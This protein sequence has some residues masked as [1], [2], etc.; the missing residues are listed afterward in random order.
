[1]SGGGQY[2]SWDGITCQGCNVELV[3]MGST[4][5]TGDF[6]SCMLTD[7]PML[8][9]LDLSRNSLAGVLPSVS[10]P[11]SI[12]SIELNNNELGGSIPGSFFSLPGSQS[13]VNL[14]H[15]RFNGTLEYP[16]GVPAWEMQT[17][18][19][20]NNQISGIIPDWLFRNT[21]PGIVGQL[22]LDRNRFSMELPSSP[23]IQNFYQ[24]V[25]LGFNNLTGSIPDWF[26]GANLSLT[27]LN[28]NNFTGALPSSMF[29]AELRTLNA[30]YN[31]LSGTIDGAVC[32]ASNLQ[33][34]SVSNTSISGTLP[35]CMISSLSQLYQ[36]EIE[37]GRLSGTLPSSMSPTMSAL[38]LQGNRI[39]GQAPSVSQQVNGSQYQISF[40]AF[41]GTVPSGILCMHQSIVDLSGNQISGT[42]PATPPTGCES[43]QI[44]DVF[45]RDNKISG[46]IPPSLWQDNCNMQ[47]FIANGNQISGSVPVF[48]S[49]SLETVLLF[50]NQLS[51]TLSQATISSSVR[52]F[53][54]HANQISGTIPSIHGNM[55]IL[56][57]ANNSLSGALPEFG[58]STSAEKQL[59]GLLLDNNDITGDLDGLSGCSSIEFLQISNNSFQGTIGSWLSSMGNLTNLYLD[60]NELSGTVPS[61]VTSLGSLQELRLHRNKFSG[62]LPSL[63]GSLTVLTA[64]A[65]DMTGQITGKGVGSATALEVVTV[66]DNTLD[67]EVPPG[68]GQLGSVEN[69]HFHNNRFSC[70]VP[71][72]PDSATSA[73]GTVLLGNIM[74]AREPSD[75]PDWVL[76]STRNTELL[77]TDF[78]NLRRIADIMWFSCILFVVLLIM[79]VVVYRFPCRSSFMAD[80]SD[81]N[82]TTREYLHVHR[83]LQVLTLAALVVPVGGLLLVYQMGAKFY[84]CVDPLTSLSLAYINDSAMES[85]SGGLLILF[86]VIASACICSVQHTI[87]ALHTEAKLRA[88]HNRR[89]VNEAKRRIKAGRRASAAAGAVGT[90]GEQDGNAGIG[91][92]HAKTLSRMF[93][94]NIRSEKGNICTC[95]G[96]KWALVLLLWCLI[97]AL[98]ASPTVFYVMAGSLPSDNTLGVK[99]DNFSLLGIAAAT[100]LINQMIA[101]RIARAFG[102]CTGFD[103]ESSRLLLIYRLIT[104]L[105]PV[106]VMVILD[107]GC[108]Q[109]YLSFWE[110]CENSDAFL[111]R[112]VST[113]DTMRDR[114]GAPSTFQF[115]TFTS[116]YLTTDDVCTPRLRVGF[117]SRRIVDVLGAFLAFKWAVKVFLQ[118]CAII[119]FNLGCK[120]LAGRCGKVLNRTVDFDL[121][122][123][124]LLGN[125]VEILGFGAFVP[126]TLVLGLLAA[127]TDYISAI[128]C[129]R[130]QIYVNT[131]G[132]DEDEKT[133][134]VRLPKMHVHVAIWLCIAVGASF[135]YENGLNGYG[136]FSAVLILVGI[137]DTILVFVVN[138][139]AGLS[140]VISRQ[141]EVDDKLSRARELK[142]MD[143]TI[144][145]S[146]VERQVLR[147]QARALGGADLADGPADA[148][149]AGDKQS[150]EGGPAGGHRRQRS[151]PPLSHSRKPSSNVPRHVRMGSKGHRRARSSGHYR[152]GSGHVRLGST[153]GRSLPLGD[154]RDSGPSR[155]RH[156][157][158]SHQFQVS[159]V[160]VEMAPVV[161]EGN[162]GGASPQ[163]EQP[164]EK[165]PSVGEQEVK[166]AEQKE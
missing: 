128:L 29:T 39:S 147:I 35:G 112:R 11:S 22:Y 132:L 163:D 46:T 111:I 59:I 127:S 107:Q 139:D 49:P 71:N 122:Y 76:A 117:C 110:T 105:V 104:S 126:I 100:V 146:T 75:V 144:K 123:A 64:H 72:T 97:S 58:C 31:N 48:C 162:E 7:L 23:G 62:S 41:E 47:T 143:R 5:M 113:T 24:T 93:D 165:S 8:G 106:L 109:Y 40:N 120:W 61:A 21:S 134:L 66:H 140:A 80:V 14:G 68:L 38:L 52:Y 25:D 88:R 94:I 44:N 43:A 155:S 85:A 20:S 149:A 55:S 101:P 161:E 136:W 19:L 73:S 70:S 79:V 150:Q 36:L 45:I 42:L 157:S 17:I 114:V 83:R 51:G 27:T 91:G 138:R 153:G 158:G 145:D 34:F 84:R 67:G 142:E 118:P 103:E 148:A 121:E 77:R 57:L 9:V 129:Y 131:S 115:G 4:D 6:P 119:S 133:E 63:P 15:N 156:S 78:Q 1:M 96:T 92:G 13:V 135:F 95:G 99:F 116:T 74:K 86:A 26:G 87:T 82:R 33:F 53:L 69:L 130:A 102:K 12:N 98:I 37:F 125:F 124:D 141:K 10:M 137:V 108:F 60:E 3:Q 32:S 28:N 16:G 154:S 2:V 90:A 151:Q 164:S 81:F 30:G 160:V 89:A 54:A 65:N 166:S 18:T 159:Q 56:T 50:S 152:L